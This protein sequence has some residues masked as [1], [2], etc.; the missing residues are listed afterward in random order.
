MNEFSQEYDELLNTYAREEVGLMGYTEKTEMACRYLR[1][2][3]EDRVMS[4]VLEEIEQTAPHLYSHWVEDQP[5]HPS[6]SKS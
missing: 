4:D 1:A 2:Q 6:I 5:W 3:L